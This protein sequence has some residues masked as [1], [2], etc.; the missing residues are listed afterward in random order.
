MALGDRRNVDHGNGVQ[1]EWISIGISTENGYEKFVPADGVA[2]DGST[3]V[4]QPNRTISANTVSA[5]GT[6]IAGAFRVVF[7]LSADFAGTIAGVT[8]SGATVR[9]LDF[10][11]GV[12][13]LSAI[14]YTRTAGSLVITEYR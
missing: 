2:S 10:D 14:E 6:V 11:G 9:S 12:A 8:R 5:G 13:K 1:Q 7:E 3:I 4:S